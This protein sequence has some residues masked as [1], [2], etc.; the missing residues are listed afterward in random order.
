LTADLPNEGV[1]NRLFL[2]QHLHRFGAMR[3]PGEDRLD[4]EEQQRGAD[5]RWREVPQQPPLCAT[6]SVE[7]PGVRRH[8]PDEEPGDGGDEQQVQ[9]RYEDH[10]DRHGQET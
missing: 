1:Q 10:R 5:D 3:P 2:L 9:Q 6:R 8:V 7:D 4:H